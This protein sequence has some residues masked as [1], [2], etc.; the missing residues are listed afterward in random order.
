MIGVVVKKIISLLM[1]RPSRL[2]R[3]DLF[4][5][6]WRIVQS[7]VIYRTLPESS[8]R[9]LYFDITLLSLFDNRTGVQRVIR[10]I[11]EEIQP[12]LCTK[13]DVVPVCCTAVTKGF[14]VL[15]AIQDKSIKLY[16]LNGYKIS[17]KKG[18]VFLSLEQAF[19][20]HLA[21][22]ETFKEMRNKG[23]KVILTVYD[24]LPLQLPYCFPIEVKNIFEKWL[25][26]SSKFAEFLCDSKSVEKDLTNF[27]ISQN[28]K[29]LNS[30]W[31]YPGSN[32]LRK[33]SSSG[34]T[35]PQT[36]YLKLIKK[37]K[38]N[39]LLVG[40]IEPRKGHKVIFDL[41]NRLWLQ[42]K[43]E[44]SLTFI[45]KEGWMV[46]DL[47]THFVTSKF[48]NERF[49]W[50]NDASDAFLEQCYAETDAVIVSSLNE[51]YGLPIL[52]AAQRNCR[53]IANEI[54][55]FREVAPEDCYFITLA[56]PEIAF[57]QL[58]DWLKKP[59]NRCSVPKPQTWKESAT[60]ILEKTKLL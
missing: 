13:Y 49:F 37:F 1:Y 21:Q 8:R 26:S 54:P 51:G 15:E 12:L 31:F 4:L 20:E 60:Q 46:K 23:C 35:V 34:I 27:F 9:R 25:L 32:F 40:T 47:V 53:V 7:S 57:L 56:N 29:I 44:V 19:I 33:V 45:G 58:Q 48:F 38:F 59:S 2:L 10:S 50:F 36:N 41:F 14:F 6:L 17:P 3:K 28:C 55:V 42:D 39:F 24:L 16:K 43:E 11:F 22:E 18:D 52:E 5:R 30:Y